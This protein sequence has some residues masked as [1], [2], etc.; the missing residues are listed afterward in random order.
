M[1]PANG[2]ERA[3]EQFAEADEPVALGGGGIK[4]IGVS[5]HLKIT[6]DVTR[7]V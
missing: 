6:R 2:D 4:A 5:E 7:D 3:G 1:D